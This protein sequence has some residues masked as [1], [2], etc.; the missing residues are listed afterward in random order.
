VVYK[1]CTQR[2][3][4]GNVHNIQARNTRIVFYVFR[5]ANIKERWGKHASTTIEGLCFLRGP[6]RGVISKTIDSRAVFLNRRVLVLSK[7]YF[8]E[9][10]SDKGW[11]P[12]I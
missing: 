5:D 8:T 6:Y 9:P 10:R 11:E 4:P 3:L 12:L 2:P 7:K 1:L